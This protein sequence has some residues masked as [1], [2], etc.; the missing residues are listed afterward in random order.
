MDKQK[1]KDYWQKVLQGSVRT[2]I[3]HQTTHRLAYALGPTI[4]KTIPVFE[5]Y[6]DEFT[7]ATILKAAWAY[8]LAKYS[9]TQDVVFGSLVHGRNQPGTQC[10]FGPC[11]NIVP[12]RVTFQH[13]W[14]VRDLIVAVHR[15]QVDGMPFEMMGSREIIQRCTSWPKW[16]YFS[17][18]I[19]HQNY[20]SRPDEE[21]P[22]VHSTIDIDSADLSTG[23]IDSVEVYITSTPN[24]TSTEI[25]ICF[26]DNV[27]SYS[28]AHS[29]ASDLTDTIK[30][31]YKEIDAV[32]MSPRDMQ[33][34][35]A[36]LP[37]PADDTNASAEIPTSEQVKAMRQCPEKLRHDLGTAWQ[38]V[39]GAQTVP[40][41]DSS[42]TFFEL[43]GDADNAGQLAAHMQRR[44]Y[45]IRIEDVFENPTW[46]RLLLRANE[47]S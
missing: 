6:S 23:D 29:L 43:G 37:S 12:T 2:A 17:S 5:L 16:G 20:E 39:L 27:I 46:S 35:P 9:A 11:V 22:D 14:S 41:D 4:I 13:N 15:S 40:D 30:Q 45:A 42:A 21:N 8:V 7:F 24:P 10:V 38:D 34:L 32:I 44:G 3:K 19:V 33:N 18:V 1:A 47:L 25:H 31:F 36:L 28:L 26:T